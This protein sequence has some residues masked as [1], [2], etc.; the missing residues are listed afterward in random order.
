MD[1]LEFTGKIEF[2][3]IS[4]YFWSPEKAAKE[5]IKRYYE[6]RR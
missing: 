1:G 3:N 2:G 6:W 5:F 4:T